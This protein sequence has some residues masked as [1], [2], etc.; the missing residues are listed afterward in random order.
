[1]TDHLVGALGGAMQDHR[2]L[3]EVLSGE[4]TQFQLGH[5][6]AVTLIGSDVAV[7]R[8]TGSRRTEL[9]G[10]A[11]LV[12][13]LDHEADLLEGGVHATIVRMCQQRRYTDPAASVHGDALLCRSVAQ[14]EGEQ[15]AESNLIS[16]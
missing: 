16:A 6:A 4:P 1:M 14:R 5:L 11:L 13:V 3:G 8:R 10:E 12:V 2:V 7:C 9:H 15:L